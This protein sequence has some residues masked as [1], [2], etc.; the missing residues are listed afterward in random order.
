[1]SNEQIIY[2]DP[3]EE[4]TDV[5]V[6]LEQTPATRIILIIPPQTQLRS[7]VGWRLLR[8]RVRELGKD[9]LIISSERQIRAVAKAAGFRGI[10][11][12]SFDSHLSIPNQ[13]VPPGRSLA[14]GREDYEIDSLVEDYYVAWDLR[15]AAQNA[16]VGTAPYASKMTQPSSDKPEQPRNIPPTIEIDDDPFAYME[17]IQPVLLPEQRGSTF[18]YDIDLGTPDLLDIPTDAHEVEIEVMGDE[19]EQVRAAKYITNEHITPPEISGPPMHEKSLTTSP[20][21]SIEHSNLLTTTMKVFYCYARE[22]IVL[23]N[24]LEKHLG[25]LKR[26]GKITG[27]YDRDI[28]AGKEWEKEIDVNLNTADIILLLISPDFIDSDYCYSVEMK[29]ALE[30]HDNG[31]AR[32]IPVILRPVDWEDAPFSMI[33]V[34]PTDGKPVNSTYWQYRD[35]AFSDIAR[36][37]RK[38]I[39]EILASR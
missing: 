36:G 35:E 13:T 21:I 1:M 31:E 38:V 16:E 33:Q 19:R 11:D 30:R 25:T 8:S 37:I 29:R 24:E 23:R 18:I 39:N 12:L 27:W 26:T 10:E 9:V 17:D 34:L 15:E 28:S 3:G 5:R 2:V 14:P 32:V 4:L 20:S 6:R 7:H 22:D